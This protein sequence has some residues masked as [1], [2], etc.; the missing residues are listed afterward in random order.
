MLQDP[1]FPECGDDGIKWTSLDFLAF[2]MGCCCFWLLLAVSLLLL[3]LYFA[4]RRYSHCMM[5]RLLV[6]SYVVVTFSLPQL[7]AQSLDK[8][9]SNPGYFQLCILE[10]DSQIVHC[11]AFVFLETQLVK[12]RQHGSHKCLVHLVS[13]HLCR[14]GSVLPF[15]SLLPFMSLSSIVSFMSVVHR[16]ILCILVI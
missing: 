7:L 10:C 1:P 2:L 15:V 4:V 16:W 6:D 5:L 3:L 13:C 11:I 12:V 9:P 8:Q 14:C